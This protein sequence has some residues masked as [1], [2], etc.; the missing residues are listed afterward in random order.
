MLRSSFFRALAVVLARGKRRTDRDAL[1]PLIG[2]VV[3]LP[4]GHPQ[5]NAVLE[6]RLAYQ[7]VGDREAQQGR[8]TANFVLSATRELTAGDEVCVSLGA[9]SGAWLLCTHGAFPNVV[10]AFNSQ[11]DELHL[12]VSRELVPSTAAVARWR[13]LARLGICPP[14]GD[15]LADA[16][17][18]FRLTARD[19]TLI[20]A[21]ASRQV[22]A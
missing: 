10:A 14:V 15:P 4:E 17:W 6:K 5:V 3:G 2:L 21:G 9:V 7:A 1:L 20:E 13:L 22:P 19:V 11:F 8:D 12:Q 16:L 18:S